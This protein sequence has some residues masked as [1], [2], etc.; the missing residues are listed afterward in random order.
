MAAAQ[1][2]FNDLLAVIAAMTPEQRRR[3]QRRLHISGLFVAE[4]LL[5]D[6]NR[7]A[8]APAVAP[9]VA[10]HFSRGSQPGAKSIPAS[11][12]LPAQPSAPMAP[13]S[14][15]APTSHAP[16]PVPSPVP[17]PAATPAPAQI[18]PRVAPAAG[19]VVLGAPQRENPA[20]DPQAMTPLPGR[21]PDQAIVV[22]FDGGSRGNPGE[23]YGSYQLRWPGNQPQVVRLRFGDN[24]TSNEAEYDTLLG[25]IDA[26]LKR[27]RDSASD[28]STARLDIRGDS[29]LV[30]KQ[31][32]GE[33]KCKEERLEQ[34]RDKVRARLSRFGEWRLTHHDRENSVRA[35]GH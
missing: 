3:L 24:M 11:L 30:I 2:S 5:T 10:A 12:P 18:N 17:A 27:L 23:G 8:V 34:R 13:H 21:A 32:L 16:A 6:Q 7:L 25:A 19:K 28:P 29:L 33:W 1:R 4:D 15:P 14:A 22:V 35:L 31:V 26:V 20:E 9:A